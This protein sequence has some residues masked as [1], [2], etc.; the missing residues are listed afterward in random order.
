MTIEQDC[1]TIEAALQKQQKNL[2]A[3]TYQS[4]AML[5]LARVENR[6]KHNSDDIATCLENVETAIQSDEVCGSDYHKRHTIPWSHTFP[7]I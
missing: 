4:S 5:D 2:K 3:A 1:N 6:Q 7:G